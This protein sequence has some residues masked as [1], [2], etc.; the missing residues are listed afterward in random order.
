MKHG[1]ATAHRCFGVGRGTFQPLGRD[2]K[3]KHQ[4]RFKWYKLSVLDE[5]SM[6]G[7]RFLGQIIF[8]LREILGAKPKDFDEECSFGGLGVIL[9]GHADQAKPI[10]DE[11]IFKPGRYTGKAKMV[12]KDG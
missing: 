9:A 5:F 11:S 6:L 4:E 2:K 12:D 3:A 7:R 1:A 10:G 8:R